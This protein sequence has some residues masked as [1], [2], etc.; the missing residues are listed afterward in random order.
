MGVAGVLI[1]YGFDI[2]YVMLDVSG[3]FKF[4]IKV[5]LVGRCFPK[6]YVDDIRKCFKEEILFKL[7][8]T[9]EA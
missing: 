5:R 8:F 1:H 9:N 3:P 2:E 7:D 4:V 6:V